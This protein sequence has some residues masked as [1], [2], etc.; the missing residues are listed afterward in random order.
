MCTIDLERK[1]EETRINL[2]T[3]EDGLNYLGSTKPLII[4]QKPES[5]QKEHPTSRSKGKDCPNPT[6]E[7]DM[8]V[9]YA[10]YN[11]MTY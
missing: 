6:F 3:T 7:W 9:V 8:S 11:I 4:F 5:S 2:P 1:N 10:C